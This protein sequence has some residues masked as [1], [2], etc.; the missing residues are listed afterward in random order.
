MNRISAPTA[1]LVRQPPARRLSTR[2]AAQSLFALF[3]GFAPNAWR[4]SLIIA[5]LLLSAGTNR[6]AQLILNGGFE[7]PNLMGSPFSTPIGVGDP[8]IPDWQVTMGNVEIVSSAFSAAFE[9]NQWLDLDGLVPG[10]IQ[11]TF[12]TVA[13]QSYQLTFAFTQNPN[14]VSASGIVDIVDGANV[15]L[16]DSITGSGS[17]FAN[18]VYSPF[19][20]TFVADSSTATLQFR[21]T[22]P[23]FSNSGSPSTQ[24]RFR[25]YLNPALL[26]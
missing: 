8:S 12:P 4:L 1:R 7:L 23:S 25:R 3:L 19:Q 18:M 10:A 15:L 14:A 20:Q 5:V 24:C 13:G 16:T 21:S 17:T 22:D 11:Q 6:A 2:H 26:H 9:G